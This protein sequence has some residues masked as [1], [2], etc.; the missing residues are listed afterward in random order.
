MAPAEP[1]L[2]SAGS[3]EH[4]AQI[5]TDIR[6]RSHVKETDFEL[7]ESRIDRQVLLGIQKRLL[8]SQ[9]QNLLGDAALREPSFADLLGV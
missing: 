9:K 1:F 6:N 4:P 8:N 2:A 7:E 3:V 5:E